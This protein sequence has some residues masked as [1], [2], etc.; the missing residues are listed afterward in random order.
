MPQRARQWYV[1]RAKEFLAGMRPDSLS[2]LT[3][4]DVDTFFRETLEAGRLTEWQ[5]RQLVEAVQLLVVDLA[6]VKAGNEVDWEVWKV[7][8]RTLG[9]DHPTLAKESSPE[10]GL[11]RRG[12]PTFKRAAERYGELKALART[13]RARQYS[14]RT[15]QSYVD[16]CHR[17]LLFCEAE[18][19]EGLGAADERT[20]S[21]EDGVTREDG[22]K[23]T[24]SQEDGVRS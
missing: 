24:G 3:G 8:G 14:I 15:E 19:A 17:F 13:L 7:A 4:E 1:L 10:A 20:G 11:H 6:Q 9:P 16:W 21:R 22:V 18:S 12:T 2:E 5:F 23:R